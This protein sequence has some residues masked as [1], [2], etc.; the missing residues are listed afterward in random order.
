ML[1]GIVIIDNDKRGR[2]ECAIALHAQVHWMCFI[3]GGF[4]YVVKISVGTIM[5]HVLC[6][7]ALWFLLRYVRCCIAR[8]VV[9]CSLL[10]GLHAL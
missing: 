2:S 8:N 3:C 4:R 7:V 6:I 9:F 1:V 10:H 5:L